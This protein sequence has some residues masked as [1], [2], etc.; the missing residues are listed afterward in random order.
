MD[1]DESELQRVHHSL[2]L[3]PRENQPPR[4]NIIRFLRDLK[5]ERERVLATAKGMYQEKR[6][7]LEELKLSFF[8]DMTKELADKRRL[9]TATRKGCMSWI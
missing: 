1:L 9:F 8:P 3:L 2:A 7:D 4:P 5:R 6:G